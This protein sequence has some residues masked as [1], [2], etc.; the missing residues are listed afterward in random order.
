MKI[1]KRII[2][3]TKKLWALFN[4]R[5]RG[6]NITEHYPLDDKLFKEVFLL[7]E[8]K[9]KGIKPKL[10]FDLGSNIGY[11]SAYFK[12]KYPK[13]KIIAVEPNSELKNTISDVVMGG[14]IDK[15]SGKTVT[16]SKHELHHAGN[17]TVRKGKGD[18]VTTISYCDLVK[19]F[20]KPDLVKIDIE[21]AEKDVLPYLTDESFVCEAH[22]DIVP[23]LDMDIMW[24][25]IE[26]INSKRYLIKR[27]S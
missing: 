5:I 2:R 27:G 15:V 13:A 6:I 9:M 8:Y 20:G 25:K 18:K 23:D 12:W 3:K 22:L 7:G 26:K 10:I 14:A 21:G 17:S 1:L 24:A 16:L 11:A 4:L 19:E